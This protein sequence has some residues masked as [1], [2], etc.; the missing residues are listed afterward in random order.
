[1]RASTTL[2]ANSAILAALLALLA[3]MVAADDSD[4]PATGF[5]CC[6]GG[7]QETTGICKVLG[8]NAFCCS[9]F[10]ASIGN[11]CDE[12]STFPTGRNLIA[13]GPV[14][15]VCTVPGVNG[16]GFVGCA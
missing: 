1:M 14:T 16:D 6:A 12:D 3:G 5:R 7:T 13:V 8:L 15:E 9:G 10:D 4:G 11:G 2:F